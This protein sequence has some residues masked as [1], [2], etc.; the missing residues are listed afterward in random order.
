MRSVYFNAT[1]NLASI[2]PSCEFEKAAA[3]YRRSVCSDR[4][5][6]V[7]AKYSVNAICTLQSI[8][9]SANKR[10]YHVVV[11]LHTW[12]NPNTYLV[13]ITNLGTSIGKT[14]VHAYI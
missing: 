5:D 6:L 11:H 13:L 10:N 12:E 8:I 1:V 3:C 9:N 7:I 14:S 4:G 2:V